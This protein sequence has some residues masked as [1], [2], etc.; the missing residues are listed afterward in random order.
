MNLI[1]YRILIGFAV[2]CTFAECAAQ[3]TF[4]VLEY[5]VENLF[6]CRHDSLKHDEEYLPGGIRGWSYRKFQ[7]KVS[8]V[9]KVILASSVKLQVPDVV[10]LC[11]VEN[12]YC[13]ESLVKYSPLREVGYRYVMTDS[14]DE[15]GIDVALLYQPYTLR[16]ID[17]ESIRIP[18][19]PEIST[20]PTRDILHVAGRVVTSDTIDFFVCHMPSRS[21]GKKKSEPYRLHTAARLK[22]A[23][24]S[25]M[26]IRQTP[27]VVI[28]G[29]FN[30]YP[31]DKVFSEVLQAVRPAE[32]IN[33]ASLYNLMDGRD[34]GTYRYRGEWGILDQ[35]IVS[36]T[37]LDGTHTLST[38]Y[39]NAQILNF[40]FLFQTDETY[41]GKKPFRTYHGMKYQG[42]FSDHLP[43]S[44]DIMIP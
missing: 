6:D 36:G 32:T 37:F 43:V 26:A 25:V 19:C 13:L 14:P 40:P 44:L 7:H 31:S 29:D 5:N 11:E 41:G 35:L 34:G 1:H 22:Q 16:L 20:R 42:G 8:A 27:Y 23:V 18:F 39:S 9:A 17:S 12:E 33:S 38:S 15:R 21:G 10:G 30:D 4:R 3:Q 24:D 28:L 2:C